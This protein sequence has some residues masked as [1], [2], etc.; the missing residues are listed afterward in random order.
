MS[1]DALEQVLADLDR[2][3]EAEAAKAD[4]AKTTVNGMKQLRDAYK[5][6]E[7]DASRLR[8]ERDEAA[9]SV[10]TFQKRE[11]FSTLQTAGLN[12][13]QSEAYE[14]I[15][16]PEVTPENVTSFKTDILGLAVSDD[17][18]PEPAFRPTATIG[19][20]SKPSVTKA[21]FEAI[22]RQDP[23]KGWALLNSGKVDF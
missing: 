12:E 13:K 22:M 6:L 9:A 5:K 14:R 15:Y 19:E 11:R 21:E 1:D 2:E 3:D 4:E 20:T 17:E 23:T 18:Q 16:G 8:K 7:R 10:E